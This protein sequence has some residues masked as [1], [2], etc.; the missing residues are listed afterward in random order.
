MHLAK[1]I[2]LISLF[3]VACSSSS[4]EASKTADE[5]KTPAS[6]PQTDEV[7][8]NTENAPKTGDHIYSYPPEGKGPHEG[9]DLA[10]IRNKLQ[11]TWLVGGSA[12]SG[13]PHIWHVQ[14]DDV[15]SYNGKGE[16]SEH[17]LQLLAPCLGKLADNGASSST[18][19]KFVFDG[20]T[21]YRGLGGA[22]VVHDEK[23]VGCLSSGVYVFENGA[24]TGWTTKAFTRDG[25][26]MFET[27]KGN[28]GYENDGSVFF[29]D[30]STSKRSVYGKQTLELRVG[31]ALMTKQMKGNKSEKVAS[32]DVAIAQQKTAIDAKEALTRPPD[33]LEFSSWNLPTTPVTLKERERVWGVA[34]DRKGGWRFAGYRFRSIADGVLW[35]RGLTDRFAPAAFTRPA[36]VVGD[37]TVG[38]AIVYQTG[39]ML[40]GQVDAISGDEVT[41]RYWS[42]SSM[43]KKTAKAEMFLPVGA[44]DYSLASPV[45]W[46]AD[47]EWD[48]GIVIYDAGEQV[49]VM[50]ATG[51]AV[52]V[53]PKAK[54]DLKLIGSKAHKKGAKVLVKQF[55]GMSP[56][57]WLP[58]KVTKVHGNGAAYEVKTDSGKIYTQS[59]AMVTKL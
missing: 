18:Y 51:S 10:E 5:T 14:G 36:S 8:S 33:A 22:G 4:E 26:P 27:T 34:L 52:R 25:Q 9:F 2:F 44:G 16:R 29:A 54:S 48:E 30:D 55:S 37:F 35:L 20:D 49:Y 32:L 47:G 1:R 46:K 42:A 6:E 12:F 40:W 31:D 53:L 57:R 7:A 11:G 19:V 13:I 59:W 15:T 28:C 38:Q 41:M 39:I 23:T 21:L 17:T 58:G 24:C 43:T 56:L 45:M 3:A 50:A